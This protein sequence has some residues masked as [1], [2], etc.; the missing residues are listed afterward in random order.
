[1]NGSRHNNIKKMKPKDILKRKSAIGNTSKHSLNHSI[2]V[3]WREQ[4]EF[5]DI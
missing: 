3:T 1:M 4:G 5:I 2:I